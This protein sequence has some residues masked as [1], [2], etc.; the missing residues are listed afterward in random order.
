MITLFSEEVDI[1]LTNSDCNT[2]HVES[3]E[4]VFFGVYEFEINGSIVIA[5]KIGQHAQDPVVAIP[6]VE[7]DGSKADVEFVLKK[8][9]F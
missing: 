3:F 6:V 7:A 8:G 1:T 9:K 5:E 4:E 2:I